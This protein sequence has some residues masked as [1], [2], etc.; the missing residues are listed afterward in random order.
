[1]A[2]QLD[3]RLAPVAR[4]DD[5]VP[6]LAEQVRDELAMHLFVFSQQHVDGPHTVVAFR[7]RRLRRRALHG[8][9]RGEPE[10][11]SASD[12]ALDPDVAAHQLD[13]ASGNRET[14]AGT[15]KPTR[16]GAVRL[17]ERLEDE[18]LL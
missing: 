13:Q 10:R 4:R 15:A 9:I 11:G 17:R 1:M 16:G 7:L 6:A 8:E 12:F 14:E 3:V 18:L 5:L 2:C